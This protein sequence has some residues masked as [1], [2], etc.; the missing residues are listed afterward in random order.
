VKENVI[1]MH[2]FIYKI[3]ARPLWEYAEKTGVFMGAEIDLTD[4]YIHLSTDQQVAQT[5]SLHFAGQTDLLLIE[6]DANGLDITWETS[7]GGQLFPHLYDSLSLSAV[8][9]I[10]PLALGSN[11]MHILPPLRQN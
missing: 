2:R 4:G 1:T 8:S 3:C 9:A 6:V 5:L 10:W 7:R 11:S